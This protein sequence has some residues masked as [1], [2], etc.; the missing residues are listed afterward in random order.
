M[1]PRCILRKAIERYIPASVSLDTGVKL[2]NII[3]WI[4]CAPLYCQHVDLLLL[5]ILFLRF[6][7]RLH[8]NRFETLIIRIDLGFGVLDDLAPRVLDGLVFLSQLTHNVGEINHGFGLLGFELK[9]LFTQFETFLE[10]IHLNVHDGQVSMSI[11]K[12][13]KRVQ[14]T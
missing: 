5:G 11:Y 12:C 10:L 6:F 8:L 13:V 7:P 1:Q 4:S 3:S 14:L 2:V 9:R